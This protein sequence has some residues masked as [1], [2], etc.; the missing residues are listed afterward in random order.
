MLDIDPFLG[1]EDLF[2][3]SQ[4]LVSYL[5]E[6][7]FRCLAHVKTIAYGVNSSSYCVLADDFG[8]VGDCI[9]E[10]STFI[11]GLNHVGIRLSDCEDKIVWAWN[12]SNG[13]VMPN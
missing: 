11:S 3:L 10:C 7:G 6:H 1:G 4:S 13:Q 12:G 8:L 9:L 5:L 2:K